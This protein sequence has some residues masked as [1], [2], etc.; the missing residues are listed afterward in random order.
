MQS[1]P[2]SEEATGANWVSCFLPC[3]G[4]W[5]FI[6][7]MTMFLL[8]A[9]DSI[10]SDGA[11]ARHFNTG[12]D[13]IKSGT[14]AHT[15][16]VWAINPQYPWLTHELFGDLV[17]GGAFLA[18][19]LNGVALVGFL[20]VGF[21]LMWSYQIARAQG[22]GR[23]SSWIVFAPMLLANSLHWL[24]RSHIFSYLFFL[25]I[26]YANIV[27]ELPYKIRMIV[28]VVSMVLWC[29]FHG[30]I[31]I[32]LFTLALPPAV[33]TL[34][35]IWQGKFWHADQFAEIARDLFI[36]FVAAAALCINVRG[37]SEYSYLISYLSHP[38]IVGKG[39]EW[40]AIDFSLGIS[41]WS[42]MALFGIFVLLNRFAKNKVPLAQWILCMALFFAGI[43][44]MRFIPYFAL[45]AL[46]AIG[47]AWGDIRKQ[48]LLSPAIS[49]AQSLFQKFCKWDG[50][51]KLNKRDELKHA[52]IKLVLLAVI[53]GIFLLEPRFKVK[54]FQQNKLPVAAVEYMKGHG[55][56]GLG[57]ALD[58]W[59]PYLYYKFNRPIFIDEKTDFYPVEF[60]KEYHAAYSGDTPGVLD[61]YKVDY[62]LIQPEAG[63]V[64]WLDKSNNWQRVYGDK[65]SVLYLRKKS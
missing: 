49:A 7:F 36:V 43:Y 30:S 1:S 57:F 32:G 61:K 4:G 10:L 29:N 55:I 45:I 8:F 41:I 63:L 6:W 60:M 17:F 52:M 16:Y 38:E 33:K 25:I 21:A 2:N 53:I 64:K 18:L 3:S 31:F 56:N 48:A 14:I 22:L 46:P 19:G 47:A 37:I 42:F 65:V 5:F 23:I 20:V 62:A 35:A 15:N 54:D 58:N 40:H 39:S 34:N 24:S 11:V 28:S 50:S 26:F 51:K 13:I 59:G 27:K 44:V 9:P 12:R